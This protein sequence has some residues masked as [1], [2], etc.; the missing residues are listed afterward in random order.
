MEYDASLHL[1]GISE[2][3]AKRGLGPGGNVQKVVDEAVLRYCDPKVPF[4]TGTLKQSALIAS[5]VG[6]GRIVYPALQCAKTVRWCWRMCWRRLR[7]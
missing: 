3:L 7:P 5:V 1:D 2:I 6:E 4:D